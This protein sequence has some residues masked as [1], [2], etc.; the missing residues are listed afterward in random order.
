MHC[1]TSKKC[2]DENCTCGWGS[3]EHSGLV[4]DG[5]RDIKDYVKAYGIQSDDI[6]EY[7]KAY[8]SGGPIPP[9]SPS[10]SPAFRLAD[11]P[12]AYREFKSIS[13]DPE[14]QVMGFLM[15]AMEYLDADLAAKDRIAQWF[16][17]S[18]RRSD[19]KE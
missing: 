14:L 5:K 16:I 10:E 7:A 11:K 12:Y 4:D 13:D 6:K 15:Q 19:G 3:G 17:I 9:E 18:T 1:S 2:S 8:G